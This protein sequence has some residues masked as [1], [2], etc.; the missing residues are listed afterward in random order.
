MPSRSLWRK[1]GCG[2]NADETRTAKAEWA[3]CPFAGF[4]ETWAGSSGSG[5]RSHKHAS[6]ETN[7]IIDKNYAFANKFD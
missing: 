4:G 3:E 6:K 1:R 7:S 2:R 5:L